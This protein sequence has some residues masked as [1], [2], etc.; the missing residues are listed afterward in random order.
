[1]FL[2][3]V[4]SSCSGEIR[5]TTTR[6]PL[7]MG[8]C[9][10]GWGCTPPQSDTTI[11]APDRASLVTSF[12]S[13]LGSLSRSAHRNAS[14]CFLGR[15]IGRGPPG[16]GGGTSRRN[17]RSCRTLVNVSTLLP[18]SPVAMIALLWPASNA[19]RGLFHLASACA[20]QVSVRSSLRC[21]PGL[22]GSVV[23]SLVRSTSRD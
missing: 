10:L 1:M 15:P 20:R 23:Y 5:C 8:C 2:C 7:T 9:E 3:C 17:T 22:G 19:N 11:V 4:P 21:G 13:G 14:P 16:T 18:T 12:L 6:C